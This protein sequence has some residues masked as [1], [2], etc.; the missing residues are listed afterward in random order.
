[1]ISSGE[2]IPNFKCNFFLNW[3]VDILYLQV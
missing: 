2:C 1:L 3:V